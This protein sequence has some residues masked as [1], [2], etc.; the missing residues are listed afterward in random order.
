MDAARRNM[1]CGDDPLDVFDTAWKLLDD[2]SAPQARRGRPDD[3]ENEC[4]HC[5][6]SEVVL[7]DGVYVCPRCATVHTRFIDAS[8]EWRSNCNFDKRG[9]DLTRCGLPCN[10]LLPNAS[11]GACI[12]FA[13][14]EPHDM[15][16]V[17]KFHVWN[18]MTYRERSLYNVFDMLTS[19]AINNGISK[20]IIDEAKAMYKK[21]YEARVSRGEN[22]AGLIASSIFM[23]C[24]R[25][26]VPRSAREIAQIF[27]L[28]L[29]TMT[30]GCKKYNEIMMSMDGD[31]TSHQDFIQRFCSRLGIDA[32]RRSVCSA[33][34]R[35]IET[36]GITCESTPP[37]IAAG[38]IYLCNVALGWGIAKKDVA[39]VCQISQVTVGKCFKR[40]DTFRKNIFDDAFIVKFSEPS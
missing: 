5:G 35:R 34:A 3:P 6:M 25:N 40:L 17:R 36:L 33:V 21:L 11:L 18:S 31:T 22:R 24:K 14:H 9:P 28:K 10:D 7:E 20:S 23:S 15:R 37:S 4:M 13:S 29:T 30:R 2:M 27:D 26:G 8:A 12:G 1:S 32:Q 38:V 16:M 19:T 39:A